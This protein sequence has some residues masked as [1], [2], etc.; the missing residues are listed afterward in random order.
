[1]LNYTVGQK[2]CTLSIFAITLSN[3]IIFLYFWHTYTEV[4]LQQS[5]NKI[6]HLSSWMFATYLVKRNVSQ[7]V[8]ISSNVRFKSHDSYGETL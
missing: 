8:H 7:F 6:A 2:N 1:M 5:G 4:N 3:H